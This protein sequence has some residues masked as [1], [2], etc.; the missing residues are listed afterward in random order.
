MKK[1]I[2]CMRLVLVMCLSFIVACGKDNGSTDDSGNSG[3][4]NNNGGSTN[5]PGNKPSKPDDGNKGEIDW[6][7]DITYEQTTLRF[8]MTNCSNQEE[9]PSGCA[10]YLAG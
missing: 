10:R 8:Q 3:S 1:K 2:M 7:E 9:L 5:K 6:W 4:A